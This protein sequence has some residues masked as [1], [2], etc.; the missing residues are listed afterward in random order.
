MK[1]GDSMNMYLEQFLSYLENEKNYS[2][3]T[4]LGYQDNIDLFFSFLEQKRISDIKKVDY[5]I[6]RVYLVELYH[7]KYSNRTISR[8]I[9]SLRS[10]FKYLE[11]EKVIEENPMVFISNPKLEQKLPSVLNY[12]QLEEIIEKPDQSTVLG[13]RNACI[14]ELLYS[15]GMRVSELV[16]LKL[17]DISLK[18]RKIKVLGKGSKE[19]FVLFGTPSYDLLT[20]YLNVREELLN[21]KQNDS[22]FLDAKGEVLTTHGVRYILNQYTKGTNIRV[23]P[24]MF[25]HTFATDMLNEGA[26]LKTVQELLGH[27]NLSTTQIY[28]HVSNERLRNVY[29]HSHPR[30]KK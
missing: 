29:L 20:S 7:H 14:F 9:S 3:Y 15:T 30:A 28:T 17:K 19:R 21:G 8:H 26:D 2:E 13:V 10:F 23:T 11:K 24:H 12:S 27:E 6:I 16:G 1:L 4:I 22:V 5:S 25:R 18:E